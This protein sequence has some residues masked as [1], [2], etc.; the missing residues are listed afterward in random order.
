MGI[1]PLNLIVWEASQCCIQARNPI[2]LLTGFAAV[3]GDQGGYY[4]PYC[5]SVLVWFEE[6]VV[7]LRPNIQARPMI[8]CYIIFNG[9]C[10]IGIWVSLWGSESTNIIMW[11]LIIA[12][13]VMAFLISVQTFDGVG[14]NVIAADLKLKSFEASRVM[15]L[16][17][18][19]TYPLVYN[20]CAPDLLF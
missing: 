18:I 1:R 9:I 6:T 19:L 2:G 20:M 5:S 17:L 10:M 11:R 8:D 15:E 12:V 3:W 16:K 13:Q 7:E 14:I 4:S